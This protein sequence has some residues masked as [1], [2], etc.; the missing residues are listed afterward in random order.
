MGTKVTICTKGNKQV[1]EQFFTRG[2]MS[3]SSAPLHFGTGSEVIIDSVI[4]RWP[5]LTFLV[6]T[7][8]P[9]DRTL[10]LRQDDEKKTMFFQKATQK[11][12]IFSDTSLPGLEFTHREDPFTD[13]GREPLMPFSLAAEGPAIAIGDLNNDGLDD[14][15]AGGAKEQAAEI[16]FQMKDGS[17][18]KMRLPVKT[19]DNF[20]DDVDAAIFDADGDNDNDIWIVHGGNEY[21]ENS[22]FFTD[23]LLINDGHGNFARGV[24][25]LFPHNGSCVC[26]G[27]MDNDGD[28]DVFSGSRSVPGAYGLS[29]F[30]YFLENNGA[31][32]FSISD[33]LKVSGMVTDAV[34]TDYDND[35]DNDLAV[36]GE[37]MKVSL[38]R[39]EKGNFEDI[40]DSSGLGKTEGWWNC[41]YSFDYDH[42][43]DLDL[44]CGNS[45]INSILKA[46]EKEPA[47][48]YVNDFD[49][50]GIP[51]P[52]ICSYVEGIS[53]PF[54]SFDEL[55]VQ[56]P[57]LSQKFR[58][59]ADF[60]DK[61]ASEIFGSG[62]W[63][64]SMHKKVQLAESS[65]FIN[66]KGA[67]KTQKM[68]VEAQFSPV[69]SM[70]P[71]DFNG[72]GFTDLILAGNNY[73]IRQSYGR[74]D[75]GY[76]WFMQGDGKGF[77]SVMPW[78]SGLRIIGDSRK[79]VSINIH[80]EKYLIAGINNGR[81]QV[82]K[83]NRLF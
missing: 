66:N 9:C 68:P 70:V 72:D 82:I 6:I 64:K 26:T 2:F 52:V 29:P 7:N 75:A 57:F 58:S 21:P 77:K 67:F 73:N 16:F 63:D 18:R 36:V 61:T 47:E 78:R 80:G 11:Q 41:I 37:W 51:D 76:G 55:K 28:I 50:N 24:T 43:G 15:F 25:G 23:N 74:F 34:W 32:R 14:V 44:F 39:N 69:R 71:D 5:D 13:L 30:S 48:L 53:Y 35:G 49:N 81:L 54:A 83:V 8:I 60:A 12:K 33:K 79:V 3:S 27:D 31:G 65:L 62:F 19:E 40:T 17:F 46:S 22:P 1:C 59:Y 10:Y 4:V 20:T 56:L 38:F 45:G 42:D